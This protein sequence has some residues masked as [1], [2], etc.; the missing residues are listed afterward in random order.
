MGHDINCVGC[1]SIIHLCYGGN[2]DER[3]L[4]VNGMPCI[5]EGSD[6]CND[7]GDDFLP[8]RKTYSDSELVAVINHQSKKCKTSA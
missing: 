2:S 5:D 7:E 4:G 3:T 6:S 1:R 8:A